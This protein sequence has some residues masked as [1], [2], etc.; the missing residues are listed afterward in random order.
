MSKLIK[1]MI[2][3][4]NER[5]DIYKG[6]VLLGNTQRARKSLTTNKSKNEYK[7]QENEISVIITGKE[8][9]ILEC[10]NYYNNIIRSS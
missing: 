6:L 2:N 1:V 9:C 5:R 10:Q 8:K 7:E 3:P 4:E